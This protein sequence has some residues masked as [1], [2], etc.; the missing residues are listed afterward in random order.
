MLTVRKV[1]NEEIQACN[2]SI[3]PHTV[4]LKDK[5]QWYA[6]TD[7]SKILSVLCIREQRGEHYIGE[8]FTDKSQRGKG[9]FTLL[10]SHVVDK[11]YTGYSVSTHALAASKRA[12]ERCGFKQ[13]AFREFKYGN[14]W[15]LRREGKKI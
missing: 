8:A 15:W 1:D 4:T 7:E 9:Y 3:D 12:F 13:Y 5:G 14:Q 11:I 10:C 6:L 2:F